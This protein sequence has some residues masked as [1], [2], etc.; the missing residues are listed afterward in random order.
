M[1]ALVEGNEFVEFNQ[2]YSDP[3][4]LHL[5]VNADRV[6]VSRD[7]RPILITAETL[8]V[9]GLRMVESDGNQSYVHGVPQEV[10]HPKFQPVV[11]VDLD[12]T[13]WP[14]AIDLVKAISYV[15]GVPATEGDLFTYNHSRQIPQW[16]TPEIN[17]LQDIIQQ[18]NHPE[19]YPFVNKAHVEAVRTLHAIDRM[20]HRYAYLTARL[21]FL[22]ETTRRVLE[23]NKLPFDSAMI[24]TDARTIAEPQ[25]GNLYCSFTDC[26]DVHAFK[27]AAVHSWF[28]AL[29]SAGWEGP[30][31][32]ID[33]T[34]KAFKD[35]II[36]GDVISIVLDGPL[37]ANIQ[38]LANEHR[39]TSWSEIAALIG[40]YHQQAVLLDPSPVRRFSLKGLDKSPVLEVD[41][42]ASGTGAFSLAHIPHNAYRFLNAD[43]AF[44]I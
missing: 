9:A 5:R 28:D 39:V 30:M 40:H 41:K 29:R 6:L 8:P 32:I 26:S 22:F 4:D 27:N 33:D 38:P 44:T 17:A 35:E 19:V 16:M 15:S 34:P 7:V 25:N 12:D 1:A 36:R 2:E 3:E 42:S 18:G 23:W 14:H 21:P 10:L 37:N 31:I 43:S 11:I 24:L 20:G 13:C